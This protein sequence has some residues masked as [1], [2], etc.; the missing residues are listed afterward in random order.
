MFSDRA[1]CRCTEL[2]LQATHSQY[3]AIF[4][5]SF[6]RCSHQHRVYIWKMED[7][8]YCNS[9]NFVFLTPKRKPVQLF[10]GQKSFSPELL[11]AIES[12]TVEARSISGK[13]GTKSVTKCPDFA[14]PLK[15]ANALCGNVATCNDQSLLDD[16][17]F[18]WTAQNWQAVSTAEQ[19]FAIQSLRYEDALILINMN[20]LP[21]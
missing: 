20:L 3:E 17:N 9:M 1:F 18:R 14:L 2:Q 15:R 11:H 5:V 10:P 8:E 19:V 6:S 4:V 16:I 21:T 7:E 12:D 13:N